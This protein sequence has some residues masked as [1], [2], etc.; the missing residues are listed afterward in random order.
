VRDRVGDRLG[1]EAARERPARRQVAQ[2]PLLVLGVEDREGAVDPDPVAVPA[3]ERR[4]ERVERPRDDPGGP[5]ERAQ[6]R[7]QDV[8]GLVRERDRE[9]ARRR[10]AVRHDPRDAAD[11]DARLPRPRARDDEQRPRAVGHRRAL[12]RVQA[13]EERGLGSSFLLHRGARL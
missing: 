11:D 4:A 7:F 8:G 5:R 6:A 9:H 1:R 13:L 12:G 10:G 2:E 3:E